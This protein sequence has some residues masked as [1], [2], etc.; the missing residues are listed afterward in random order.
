[1]VLAAD[2]YV[3]AKNISETTKLSRFASVAY[4]CSGLVTAC[5]F[6][7]GFLYFTNLFQLFQGG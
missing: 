5:H 1:M 3:P 4:R 7:N 6:L 2:A